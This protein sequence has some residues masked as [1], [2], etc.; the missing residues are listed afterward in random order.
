MAGQ[1]GFKKQISIIQSSHNFEKRNVDLVRLYQFFLVGESKNR[2]K[3]ERKKK[4]GKIPWIAK[5]GLL[6]GLDPPLLPSYT[7]AGI[8]KY[9]PKSFMSH[10]VLADYFRVPINV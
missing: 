3:E 7:M 5:V 9:C 4:S 6:R 10:F 8:A 2:R 1:Y